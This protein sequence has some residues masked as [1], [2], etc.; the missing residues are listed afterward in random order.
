[1]PRT[2][3]GELRGD[4]LRVVVL[5]ARWNPE[6]TDRLLSGALATLAAAGVREADVTVVEVPGAFELPAAARR[7]ASSGRADAVVALGCVLRGETRHDE[8]IADACARGLVDVASSTGVPVTFGV[9]T[10]ATREQALARSDSA[11]P[12]GKDGKGGHK[13]REA[14]EAAVVLARALRAFDGADPS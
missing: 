8:V 3:R 12:R 7:V 11:A 1:M 5:V 6:V 2:I 13:G 14:A 9:V 4:G 10:A